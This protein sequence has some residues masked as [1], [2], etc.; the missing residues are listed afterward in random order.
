MRWLKGKH[1]LVLASA[2]AGALG[3]EKREKCIDQGALCRRRVR[4]ETCMYVCMYVCI[5]RK[6]WKYLK[7]RTY[8]ANALLGSP[9]RLMYCDNR[10]EC[11]EQLASREGGC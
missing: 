6:C 10:K 11:V 9:A 4:R 2:T 3:E 5:S 7:I 1:P 8:M